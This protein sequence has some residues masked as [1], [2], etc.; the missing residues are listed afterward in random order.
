MK[1]KNYIYAGLACLALSAC[2]KD[3]VTDYPNFLGGVN[4]QSGVTVSLPKTFSADENIQPFFVPITVTGQTNG[5]VVVNVK[6]TELTSTPEGTEPAKPV[7]HFNV[8]STTINIPEGEVTGGVE[9]YPIW[10]TGE[11]NDDRVFEISIVSAEGATVE[12]ATCEVTI[13]NIDDP[14]TSMCG[15]WKC[16][17]TNASTGAAIEWTLNFVTAEPGTEDYGY[18]LFANGF[19]GEND[20]FIPFSDFE[21]DVETGKGSMKIAY[22]EL[23]A[24]SLFNYGLEYNAV[25]CCMY[26]GASG[27]SYEHEAICTFDQNYN[28]I[29]VPA[30]ANII[31]GLLYYPSWSF[32][33]YTVGYIKDIKFT[34]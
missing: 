34:R 30:D 9:V 24:N 29:V 19:A 25:P 11:I 13:V 6:V 33:G 2:S 23:M 32:S 12:N 21:F 27:V 26:R 10:V 14:Y 3:E 15:R 16:T 8:T 5:K 28:E 7:E 22:G 1:F 18:F 20:Y 31:A 4:T 17:A